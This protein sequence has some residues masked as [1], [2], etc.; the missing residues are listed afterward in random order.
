MKYEFEEL[1]EEAFHL[2]VRDASG[3][4]VRDIPRALKMGEAC[5]RLGRSRRHLYRYVVCGWLRPAVKFS[6]ELFFDE[7]DLD[8]L[9][10]APRGRR[11]GVPAAMALLFPEYD[12][13][14]LE[15]ER[16]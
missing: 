11:R 12:R 7:K 5:R 9:A 14:V 2:Q 4:V 1:A 13:C 3:R 16:D 6:G 10:A 8:T 15:P